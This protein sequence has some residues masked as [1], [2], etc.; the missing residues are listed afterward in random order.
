[1]RKHLRKHNGHTHLGI[2]NDE[3]AKVELHH[4]VKAFFLTRFNEKMMP[5]YC[6]VMN[7]T[8]HIAANPGTM[9]L[10]VTKRPHP[11]PP[12]RMSQRTKGNRQA[13]AIIMLNSNSI[14]RGFFNVGAGQRL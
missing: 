2:P 9:E 10:T 8:I 7:A 12:V 14:H 11:A 4:R 6:E 13:S 5:R 1:M 3:L